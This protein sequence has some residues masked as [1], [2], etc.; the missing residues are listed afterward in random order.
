MYNVNY[1]TADQMTIQ[2]CVSETTAKLPRGEC[3][4]WGDFMQQ[5]LARWK[6]GYLSSSGLAEVQKEKWG[7]RE[8]VCIDINVL[9]RMN[10]FPQ[11]ELFIVI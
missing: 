1:I 10:F 6:E 3:R 4:D 2:E 8:A 11:L 9:I 5:L 7:M